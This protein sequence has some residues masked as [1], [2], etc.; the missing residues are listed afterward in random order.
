MAFVLTGVAHERNARQFT[1]ELAGSGKVR[2]RIVV[3][4]DLLLARKYE[5]PLQELPLLCLHLLDGRTAPAAAAPPAGNPP[6][7]R[8]AVAAGVAGIL[9]PRQFDSSPPD[10]SD[11]VVFGEANMI[12]YARLRAEAKSAAER[13]RRAHVPRPSAARQGSVESE[14]GPA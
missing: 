3:I 1:F 14:G 6:P 4:A 5:I 9:G 10:A 7:P 11:T 13:K 2:F 12:E 8:A